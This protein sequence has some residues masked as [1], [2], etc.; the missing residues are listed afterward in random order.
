MGQLKLSGTLNAGPPTVTA[1]TFPAATLSAPIATKEDPKGYQRA[2]GILRRTEN[3]AV[4][5]DLAEPGN[6]VTKATFL[7]FKSD[8]S[9]DLR[10]TTDDGAGGNVVSVAPVEGIFIQE[11]PSAKFLKLLEMLGNATIEYFL[12]GN[13]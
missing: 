7:Y 2:T 9:I 10:L 4:F 6:V 8:G 12:S 11:F 1:S 13:Q 5:T 3:F